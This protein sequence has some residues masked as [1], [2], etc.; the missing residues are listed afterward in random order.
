MGTENGH[1]ES[2]VTTTHDPAGGGRPRLL[3]SAECSARMAGG[4]DRGQ[5]LQYEF[6]LARGVTT[7]GS[8]RDAYLRLQ[9]IGARVAEIHR[10]ASDEYVFVPV[11]DAA[12]SRLNGADAV[13]A[14]LHTG[15]RLEF[16]DWVMSYFREEYADHGRPFGG[17]QGGELSD[18]KAQRKPRPRGTSQAGGHAQDEVNDGEYF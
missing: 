17:R 8:A 6:N 10:D 7:I 2:A 12:A 18:Q 15:D 4:D 11:G 3:F 16:G 5:G 1:S 13:E 14:P 9:G